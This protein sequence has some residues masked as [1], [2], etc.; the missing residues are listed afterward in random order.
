MELE[1]LSASMKTRSKG[2]SGWSCAKDSTAGP[3]KM[4]AWLSTPAAL[5]LS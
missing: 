1:G 4:V 5:K 2:T 3:S